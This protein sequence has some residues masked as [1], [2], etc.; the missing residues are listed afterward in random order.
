MTTYNY[1]PQSDA[2]VSAQALHPHTTTP[3][4]SSTQPNPSTNTHACSHGP[5]GALGRIR[6]SHS[7]SSQLGGPSTTSSPPAPRP[8]THLRP[9]SP[10]SSARPA[11]CT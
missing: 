4:Q 10:A 6:Q 8:P 9:S 7:G 11:K 2:Q 5:N 3:S 1:V